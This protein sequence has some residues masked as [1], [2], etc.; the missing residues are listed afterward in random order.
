MNIL[1][2]QDEMCLSVNEHNILRPSSLLLFAISLVSLS[3]LS[4]PSQM[5]HTA[6]PS[7]SPCLTLGTLPSMWAVAGQLYLACSTVLAACSA[8][9]ICC[10]IYRDK[11]HVKI[12]FVE[13]K[14][15]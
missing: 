13:C 11:S 7:A 5:Y 8:Y 12:V 10:A 6:L 2:N 4:P 3:T 14:R 15:G 9:F 1:I